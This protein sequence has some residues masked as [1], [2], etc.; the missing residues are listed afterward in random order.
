MSTKYFYKNICVIRLFSL[1]SH[2]F[3]SLSE[4][5]FVEKMIENE[6]CFANHMPMN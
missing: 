6:I 2:I 1:Q 3:M 4:I 5:Y